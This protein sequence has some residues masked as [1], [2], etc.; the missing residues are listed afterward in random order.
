MQQDTNIL[1]RKLDL[2]GIHASL[3]VIPEGGSHLFILGRG[4]TV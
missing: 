3:L 2:T 4:Q 1:K